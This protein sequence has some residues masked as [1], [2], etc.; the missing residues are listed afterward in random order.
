MK[1][2]LKNVPE[3]YTKVLD[4]LLKAFDQGT[5]PQSVLISAAS[6]CGKK[7]LALAL[8]DILLCE[9]QEFKP[10][11]SCLMCR[12]QQLRSDR[13]YWIPPIRATATERDND[14]KLSEIV[15]KFS[16]SFTL[17]PWDTSVA[18][19]NALIYIQQV[20]VL[21]KKLAMKS[22]G[23]R[24]IIIPDA[25][26]LQTAGA[27]AL[28]KTLE[29][30][31]KGCYFILTTSKK[32]SLLATIRSR[33]VKVALPQLSEQDFKTI[34]SESNFTATETPLLYK[35][36]LGSPGR[37]MELIQKGY[38]D[39]YKEAESW[40]EACLLKNISDFLTQTERLEVLKEDDSLILFLEFLSANLHEKFENPT[41][42][43]ANYG[44]S[45][46]SEAQA[47]ITEA[48]TR[49]QASSKKNMVLGNLGLKLAGL[50]VK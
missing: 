36:A 9:S 18:P 14:E 30:V 20:R 38:L 40:L 28:L 33:C 3:S 23:T 17:N 4:N 2:I 15:Q 31:P 5:F 22:A 48:L 49:I 7:K 21:L 26:K 34:L 42:Q 41:D 39:I 6:G 11:G 10:C 12:N 46:F 24:V 35:L 16:E 44:L 19:S 29:E 13:L 27:N 37:A 32:S 1:L 8:A 47:L 45:F 43:Y 25:E 50:K